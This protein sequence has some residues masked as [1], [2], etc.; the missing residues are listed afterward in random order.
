MKKTLATTPADRPQPDLALNPFAAPPTNERCGLPSLSNNYLYA[1]CP[2]SFAAS[3][4]AGSRDTLHTVSG[5]RIH[6]ALETGNMNVLLQSEY[7]CVRELRRM[8]REVLERYD[9]TEHDQVEREVRRWFW[10]DTPL[11]VTGKVK[12]GSGRG[13]VLYVKTPLSQ[14]RSGLVIDYKSGRVEVGEKGVVHQARGL[15]ALAARDLNLEK[16]YAVILQPYARKARTVVK[17]YHRDEL[18]AAVGEI[19]ERF[20]MVARPGQPRHSG[21]HCKFCPAAHLCEQCHRQLSPPTPVQA[22]TAQQLAHRLQQHPVQRKIMEQ[23]IRAAFNLMSEGVT[24]PGF[25]RIPVK[26]EAL[27]EPESAFA[28]LEAEVGEDVWRSV[29]IDIP[30]ALELLHRLPKLQNLSA[31]DFFGEAY[32][33]AENQEGEWSLVATG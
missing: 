16:V 27:V 28:M 25:T 15:A 13:D 14:P 6:L 30:A 5:K 24:V 23:E 18:L 33:H 21:E 1:R 19:T 17:E 29:Y 2:G 8:E 3:Q 32:Y 31:A 22:L 7:H 26:S 9:F 4:S 10:A 20:V 12:C 11:A